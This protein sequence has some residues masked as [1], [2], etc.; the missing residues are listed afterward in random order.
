M[1]LGRNLMIALFDR[2]MTQKELAEKIG[3]GRPLISQYISG[4]K[5]PSVEMC[6]KIADALG[7][8]MDELVREPAK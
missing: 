2:K 6:M 3:C 5:T 8:T 1:A 4:V 7:I